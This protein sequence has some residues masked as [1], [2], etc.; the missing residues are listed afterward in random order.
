M[1]VA[2]PG[3][4]P[5]LSRWLYVGV[6]LSAVAGPDNCLRAVKGVATVAMH[7]AVTVRTWQMDREQSLVGASVDRRNI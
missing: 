3:S 1:V 5:G 2:C 7:G 6:S 4:V